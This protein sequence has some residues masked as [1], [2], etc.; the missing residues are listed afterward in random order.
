MTKPFIY[1][2]GEEELLRAGR[3]LTGR[4]MAE[5]KDAYNRAE[6]L[7]ASADECS[8][9]RWQIF[10]LEG[11]MLSA[12]K[13]ADAI[14]ARG[15]KD[16]H[17]LWDGSELSGKR[18][19]LRCLHG[20][21][22]TIQMLRYIPQILQ[23][24]EKVIF[25]VQPKL[26]SLVNS[27]NF[28]GDQRLKVITWGQ[29]CPLEKQSWDAQIEIMELPYLFRTQTSDLPILSNY[30]RLPTSEIE[31][32]HTAMGETKQP[33]IGLVWSA[34][35][36][37]PDRALP[38]ELFCSLLRF[39]LEFWSLVDCEKRKEINELRIDAFMKDANVVGEGILSLSAVI[40]NLS[41]VITTDTL[42]AHLA[43]AIGVPVWLMLPSTADWRWMHAIDTCPW[44]PSMRIFRQ[45]SPNQW[46][47]VLESVSHEL[48]TRVL[49]YT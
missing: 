26:V 11:N 30:L 29:C 19:I 49:G 16:A 38:A 12:W 22:D 23:I 20:Y 46:S 13:E 32:A 1:N 27:L 21:G 37:N 18:I 17:R 8:G 10:M 45:S 36:W 25:Q 47:T 2:K 33:R 7:G 3:L 40:A 4:Q 42:S 28:A 24:A 15:G 39:P 35:E 48:Q 14:R 31:R 9:G 5:A 44:Y 41:L 6:Y 43:G 34:G